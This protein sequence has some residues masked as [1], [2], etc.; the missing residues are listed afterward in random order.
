M[1]ENPLWPIC[2]SCARPLIRE[3]DFGVDADGN[4]NLKYCSTCWGNNGF[5]RPDL[6]MDEMIGEVVEQIIDRTGMPRSRAEEITRS[7]IPLLE[8]WREADR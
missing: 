7:V 5:R 6:T 8:R 3:E 2:Q 1:E 4:R